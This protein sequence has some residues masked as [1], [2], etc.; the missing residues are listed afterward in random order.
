MVV[1][2]MGV[3]VAIVEVAGMG[4]GDADD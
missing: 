1:A 3:L 2:M 4:P